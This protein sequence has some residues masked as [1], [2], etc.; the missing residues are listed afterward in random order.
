MKRFTE[1][2]KWNDPWFQ[3]LKPELKLLWLYIC[4]NCDCAGIWQVNMRLAEFS[5]GCSYPN[6]TLRDAFGDRVRDIGGGKIWI[7]KFCGFQYGLLSDNCP[8]HRNV[9]QRLAVFSLIEDNTSFSLPYAK[10]SVTPQEKEKEKETTK[11]GVGENELSLG[12]NFK[13]ADNGTAHSKLILSFLNETAGRKY[14]ETK[15]HLKLIVCRLKEVNGD[16][17]GIKT[18]IVRQ[19]KRWGTD[20]KMMEYLRP[21]TLFN[22]TKFHEYY[23][24]RHQPVINP[25][26][27][28]R[29]DRNAG[30]LNEGRAHLYANVGKVPKPIPAQGD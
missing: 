5:L 19:V 17:D 15:S 27:Q 4:D 14:R 6:L 12:L 9:I 1:T 20:E 7:C 8:P 2:T 22:A 26:P 30:T 18:M 23:D 28:N 11:G 16:V 25:M 3:D 10:G 21:Q 24:N 29:V 13:P